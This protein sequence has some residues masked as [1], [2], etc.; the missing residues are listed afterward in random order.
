MVEMMAATVRIFL[1]KNVK[2]IRNFE[3]YK[4][5]LCLQVLFPLGAGMTSVTLS[6]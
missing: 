4:L 6:L 1:K 2:R 3:S 5:G